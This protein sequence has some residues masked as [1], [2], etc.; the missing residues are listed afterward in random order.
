MEEVK[1]VERNDGLKQIETAAK[2][3]D[4]KGGRKEKKGFGGQC[5]PDEKSG[6]REREKQRRT[7]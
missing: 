6:N 2:S 5:K 4:A 7:V 1:G 3:A